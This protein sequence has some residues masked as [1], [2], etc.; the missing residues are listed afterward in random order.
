MHKRQKKWFDP[1]KG[2][3]LTIVLLDQIGLHFF[4]LPMGL[5]DNFPLHATQLTPRR[6]N[7]E[8]EKGAQPGRSIT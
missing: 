7:L 5:S 1:E 4:I 2:F 3:F 8:L 6:K